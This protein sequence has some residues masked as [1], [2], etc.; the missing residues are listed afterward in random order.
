MMVLWIRLNGSVF[1]SKM[2]KQDFSHREGLVTTDAKHDDQ[3]S[4][5][6]SS[7]CKHCSS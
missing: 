6:K 2:S 4:K 1:V 3:L 5:V 7:S